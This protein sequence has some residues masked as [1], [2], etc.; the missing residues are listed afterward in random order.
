M[1]INYHE[2]KTQMRCKG[3]APYIEY[4]KAIVN[5]TSTALK[6]IENYEFFII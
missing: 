6:T 4:V 5:C 3:G 1:T 2:L